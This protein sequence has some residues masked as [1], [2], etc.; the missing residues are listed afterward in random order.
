MNKGGGAKGS[1]KGLDGDHTRNPISAKEARNRSLQGEA[2]RSEGLNYKLTIKRV[3][4]LIEAAAD[5]GASEMEFTAPH[6]VLDGCLGDPI[7]LAKQIKARLVQ[8]DY[9]VTRTDDKLLI[10]W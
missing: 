9:N 8:L 7:V 5:K 4:R 3:Y 2:R 6:F 10:K 1:G